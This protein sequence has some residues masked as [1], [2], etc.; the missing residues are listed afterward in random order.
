MAIGYLKLSFKFC[1]IIPVHRYI[2]IQWSDN[3]YSELATLIPSIDFSKFVIQ[4]NWVT[5]FSSALSAIKFILAALEL[6]AKG[7][8]IVPGLPGQEPDF[9]DLECSLQLVEVDGKYQV[10]PV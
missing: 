7:R 5:W 6:R 10:V 1:D 9:E 2:I 3:L 8:N 4:N